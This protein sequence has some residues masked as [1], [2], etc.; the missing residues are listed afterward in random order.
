MGVGNVVITMGSVGAMAFVG[1]ETV[2]AEACKVAAVDTTA[3]GAT[4]VGA[5]V[6]R[7]AAGATVREAMVFANK[8]SS[9][10]VTRKGAQQAIP[11]R[12]EIM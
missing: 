5:M 2:F 3:A 4:F 10:T 6:T 12:N 9:V 8:A 7:L 11:Y 1:S